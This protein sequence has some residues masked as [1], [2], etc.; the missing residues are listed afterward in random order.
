MYDSHSP[1]Y[2]VVI[3]GAGFAGLCQARHLLLNVPNIKVALVDPRP[4]KRT[5]KD[6]KIGEFLIEVAAVFL[7][8][9]LGLHD[10]LIENHTPKS[11]LNFHWPKETEETSDLDDYYHVWANRQ[12]AIASFHLQR[13]KFEQDLLEMN[14]NMGASF[15]HGR[16]VDVDLT[17]GDESKTVEVKTSDTK[18]TLKAKHV[19]DAAGRK[20]L[21][22][23]KT[24]N[25]VFDPEEL[26]GVDNG[27]AWLRVK[28]VDRTLFHSGYHPEGS[29]NS[30]YYAT[31]HFFN[32]RPNIS[33][34]PMVMLMEFS[35]TY[36]DSSSN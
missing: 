22:G 10:Y 24:D 7:C 21:I 18:L 35:L 20:F 9:E 15:Y 28:N 6:L 13:A 8:K 4:T 31:N 16:V 19:I 29:S 23:R 36:A 3:M 14:Q 26:L 30:H 2:D 32:L 17:P 34:L 12:T 5:D 11:G 27:S 33:K 1:E 25:L